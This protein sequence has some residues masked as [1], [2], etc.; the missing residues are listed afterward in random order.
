MKRVTHL[1]TEYAGLSCNGLERSA[2]KN[3]NVNEKIIN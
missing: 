1:T 2:K 3:V